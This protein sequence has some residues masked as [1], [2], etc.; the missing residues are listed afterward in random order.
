MAMDPGF[1]PICDVKISKHRLRPLPFT[2]HGVLTM[3]ECTQSFV[4]GPKQVEITCG[5]TLVCVVLC[6]FIH[7][8]LLCA[9]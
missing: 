3:V 8:D 9:H 5:T 6:I 4:T 2:V 1:D 7:N